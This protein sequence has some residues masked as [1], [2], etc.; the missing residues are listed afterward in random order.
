MP[1]SLAFKS[2]AFFLD[3]FV[4]TC[5]LLIPA[6]LFSFCPSNLAG[7]ADFIC[8]WY[9][10]KAWTLELP[11]SG[12]D[13]FNA[14]DDL[15]W[16]SDITGEVAGEVRST[17]DGQFVF[18]RVFGAGHMVSVWKEKGVTSRCRVLYVFGK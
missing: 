6:S 4:S 13:E 10:N 16:V 17:P 5:T 15:D 7:D 14:A 3:Y 18:L 11:W 1:V 2:T 8:N 12:Q 9:G